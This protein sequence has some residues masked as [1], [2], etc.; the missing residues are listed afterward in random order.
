MQ[1]KTNKTI[2]REQNIEHQ[3]VTAKDKKNRK[4][5]ERD[6]YHERVYT[7]YICFKVT[8]EPEA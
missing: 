3:K 4:P 6:G 8:I 1:Y 7:L 5:Y 2:I